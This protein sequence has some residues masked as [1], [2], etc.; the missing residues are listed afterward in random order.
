MVAL[1]Q[2]SGRRDRPLQSLWHSSRGFEY[3]AGV[4]PNQV[5][6]ALDV[7]VFAGTIAAS[8]SLIAAKSPPNPH[9][10]IIT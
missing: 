2:A 4:A 9:P 10:T 7:H 5:R 8:R 1:A 3:G 6:A